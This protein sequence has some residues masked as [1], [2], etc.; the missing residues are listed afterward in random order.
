MNDPFEPFDAARLAYLRYLDSPFRLR[1]E[2]L[3]RERRSLLDADG[4]LYREP[5]FEPVAP[6]RTSD[7]NVSEAAASFALSADVAQF[8]AKGL[9]SPERKLYQHQLDAWRCSRQGEAVVVT[10]G[11]GSGKTESYLLPV[12]ASLVEESR[13]W[14]SAPAP[15][16]FW[17]DRM[18]GGRWSPDRAQRAH[19]PATRPSAIRGLFLFPLNAL[20]E[21]QLVRIR[22]ACDSPEASRWLGEHRP[23]QRFWFGRYNGSTVVPGSPSNNTKQTD[24]KKGL[25]DIKSV[26]V[27]LEQSTKQGRCG[28][29]VLYYFQNPTGSEM[30]SR[31]DMQEDPPDI[32][33]TNYSMLNIMLMRES[34][35]A[36]LRQDSRLAPGGPTETSFTWCRR[37]AHLPGH[38][39]EPRWATSSACSSTGSASPG[40]P[41]AP[42]HRDQCI[43]RGQ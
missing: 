35:A 37:A 10:T 38:A 17:W 2:A 6:Y 5:I 9:F 30:W 42:H 4:Q 21:D 15:G 29:E 8:M 7:M 24:L 39:R 14:G 12:F 1:Y 33:I 36:H 16:D 13:R 43:S 31:W 11:T 22:K 28:P 34:R 23:G 40:S 18:R 20:V 26:W 19:E 25:T 3:M 41:T 27:D 32:L